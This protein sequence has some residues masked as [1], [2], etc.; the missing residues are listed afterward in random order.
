MANEA[1]KAVSNYLS[2]IGRKGGVKGEGDAKT[3]AD[4]HYQV[5]LPAARA[6]ARK[7][8]EGKKNV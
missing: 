3:R 4:H 2:N 1:K 5:V 8:R 7:R 6:A